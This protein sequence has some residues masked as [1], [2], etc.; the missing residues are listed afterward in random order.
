MS[1]PK[2]PQPET[3]KTPQGRDLFQT[4]TYAVDLLVPFIPQ[5]N[6]HHFWEPACGEGK[7]SNV[8][9]HI[10][11]STVLST[12]IRKTDFMGDDNIYNFLSDGF[13]PIIQTVRKFNETPPVI[14]TNPPFSL[15]YQFI[16]KAI[17]YGLPFAFLIPFDMCGKMA[18]LFMDYGCQG[19][20]PTSRINFITPTGKTEASG[21]TS[22]FHSFWLT[23]HFNLP[24]LL[25]FVDLNKEMRKNI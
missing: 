19:V 24:K 11:N 1:K 4:P 8:L 9:L 7:I 3:P 15:K 14:I 22:P 23:R 17:E 21:H 10:E 25:T 2:T 6:S 5:S 20:V 12:D 13:S 16:H 18:H